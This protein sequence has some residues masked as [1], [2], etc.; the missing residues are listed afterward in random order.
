MAKNDKNSNKTTEQASTKTPERAGQ[1]VWSAIYVFAIIAASVYYLVIRNSD[2]LFMAQSRQL[3]YGSDIYWHDCMKLPGGLLAWTGSYLTQFLYHPALG[4]TMLAALWVLLFFICKKAF[5]LSGWLSGLAFIPAV[6][7]LAS[8]ID[9]GYWI[10]YIKIPGYYFRET[11]GFIA[12]ALLYWLG[13]QSKKGWTAILLNVLIAISYTLFGAFSLLAL[14]MLAA[15]GLSSI[16]SRGKQL[17][18]CQTV[19]ALVLLLCIPLIFYRVYDEMPLYDAWTVGFP[20]FKAEDLISIPPMIPFVVSAVCY[21]AYS[22]LPLPQTKAFGRKAIIYA[23]NIC[24]LICALLALNASDFDNYN[25]HAETRMYRAADESRW[26]DVLLEASK[27]PGDATRQIVMLRNI[28]LFNKGTAGNQMFHYNNMGEPPYVRDSLHVHLVQTAA[29]LIYLHHGKTNFTVR[30]CIENSVEYDYSFN[31]LKL[32]AVC[33]LI[34]GELNAARKYLDILSNTIYYKDWA[35]HY[36]PITEDPSL[37]SPAKI[38]SNYPELANIIEL[39][40]HMGTTLDG[41][42]G[43]CEMYIINYFSNTMNKDSRY[44]QEITLD[45][46]IIQKDIQLFW[47]HFMLYATLN[48]DKEMP[49]HYQEAAY[50]YGKLEPQTMNTSRMP[51]DKTRIVERYDRFNQVSQSLLNS[52]MTTQQVGEAMKASFGDTFWWFYFFCRDVHSY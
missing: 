21:V 43:L 50:L 13:I 52:R 31:N 30:W 17:A 15:R 38:Q 37:L 6:C 29:P 28:A 51:F 8:E 36:Q 4:S 10:Y 49:I 16:R 5:R 3:W 48:Q 42:N 45:Y 1:W 24:I 18:T 35:E 27:V 7:L 20:I 23:A 11:L 33:S 44:L 34:H 46:A 12:A 40:N 47:P 19:S 14:L 25:F 26:D 32:L 41:D 22:I 9:L 2:M 39:R